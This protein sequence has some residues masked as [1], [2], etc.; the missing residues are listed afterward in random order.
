MNSNR[1]NAFI[2]VAQYGSFSQAAEF[3]YCTQP[4]VSKKI[5]AL[6][7]E[8]NYLL[9]D[10]IGKTVQLTE[11]GRLLLPQVKK[12]LSDYAN[13]KQSIAD[14]DNEISGIVKI[15]TSH[16]IGLHHLPP[17]LKKF[18]KYYPKVTLDLTFAGSEKTCQMVENTEIE[19]GI[20]TLPQK[21]TKNINAFYFKTD[22]LKICVSKDHP[23]T[24]YQQITSQQLCLY[25]AVLPTKETYTRQ[26]LTQNLAPDLI[27]KTN[28]ETDYLETLKMLCLVGLGWSLLPESLINQ[29]LQPLDIIDIP[30]LKRELGVIK[31]HKRTLSNAAQ[32]FK[33]LLILT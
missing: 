17:I 1:L 33:D 4:A 25:G 32:K 9:F 29:D 24:Q 23:L 30:P 8:L 22:P 18:R 2:A 31:H 16:H 19:L 14:L 6:E 12:I 15:G 27:I 28:I 10:R 11:A 26:I 20:I 5:A 7:N 3:L 13:I 21:I